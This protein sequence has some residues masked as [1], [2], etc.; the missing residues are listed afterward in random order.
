MAVITI[1]GRKYVEQ[2]MMVGLFI[3]RIQKLIDKEGNW[4]FLKSMKESIHEKGYYT[5]KQEEA[6]EKIEKGNYK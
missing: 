3:Q 6:I 5:N 2:S 4:T 1:H